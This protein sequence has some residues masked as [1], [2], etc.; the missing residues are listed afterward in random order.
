MDIV[1]DTF[2]KP[3]TKMQLICFYMNYFTKL[4]N[5]C[6]PNDRKIN[7]KRKYDNELKTKGHPYRIPLVPL[8]NRG[9]FD[10]LC[11]YGGSLVIKLLLL[12]PCT[13]LRRELKIK[14]TE[15][16]VLC[17]NNSAHDR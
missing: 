10:Q 9:I 6:L 5:T 12:I 7:P 17:N 16:E 1:W 13:G 3:A 4:Q 8:W 2:G 11:N 14:P 15:N